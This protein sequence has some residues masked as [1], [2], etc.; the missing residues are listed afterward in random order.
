MITNGGFWYDYFQEAFIKQ[1]SNFYEVIENRII[2]TFDHIEEEAQKV[3]NDEWERICTSPG[4]PDKDLGDFVDKV[5]DLGIEYYRILYGIKQAFLNVTAAS[6]YHL[7]EQQLSFFLRHEFLPSSA[8]VKGELINDKKLKEYIFSYY[9][10]MDELR[11]VANV[12]KHAEGGSA[13]D[14]RKIRP[15]LFSNPDFKEIFPHIQNYEIKNLYLPLAGE[16]FYI[17]MPDIKK[18]KD[19]LIQFWEEFGEE[20]TKN[21]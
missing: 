7:F 18:Y 17:R 3:E 19:L 14:L 10:E 5:R 21:P 6:L 2:P 4:D 13:E 8:R 1:I 11:L 16:D 20:I 12:V 15:D 9:P